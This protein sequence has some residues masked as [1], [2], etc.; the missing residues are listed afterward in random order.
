MDAIASTYNG[1]GYGKLK[2]AVADAVVECLRPVQSRYHELRADEPGLV[3]VLRDGAARAQVK[4][5]ATL[6]RVHESLGFI[7]E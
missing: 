5:D 1:Q 7:A 4:A 3:R 6:R 2:G